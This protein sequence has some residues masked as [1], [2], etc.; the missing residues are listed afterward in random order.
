[1]FCHNWWSCDGRWALGIPSQG[2][3]GREWPGAEVIA[4]R[5]ARG[6]HGR[7]PAKEPAGGSELH[8]GCSA[9]FRGSL[10]AHCCCR[11][12]AHRPASR[13]ALPIPIAC[14]AVRTARRIIPSRQFQAATKA[15][16]QSHERR[17]NGQELGSVNWEAMATNSALS[18]A[19]SLAVVIAVLFF[20]CSPSTLVMWPV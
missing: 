11:I 17:E 12:G 18:P 19:N 8:G 16:E 9:A 2:R 6:K 20:P 5:Q 1:M 15:R 7:C 14:C 13:R 10:A 3:R 4:R